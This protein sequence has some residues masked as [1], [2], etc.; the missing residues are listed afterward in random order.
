MPIYRFH[1]VSNPTPEVV[2]HVQ[3]HYRRKGAA[4]ALWIMR[5]PVT[6]GYERWPTPLRA[7]VEALAIAERV[8]QLDIAPPLS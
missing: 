6:G 1:P 8:V 5:S 2:R 7:A 3:D 4:W